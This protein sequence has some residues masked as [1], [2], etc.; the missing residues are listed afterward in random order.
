MKKILQRGRLIAIALMT[1]ACLWAAPAPPVQAARLL[2]TNNAATTIAA[3]IS[4]GATTVSV[5]AGTG[6]HFPVPGSGQYFRATFV[7]SGDSTIFE[8]VKVT[9][10]AG[11]TFTIVRAQEATSARSW[12]TGDSFTLLPTAADLSEFTQADDLQLAAGGYAADTG[13][14]NAY[15]VTLTPAVSTH[16]TGMPIRWKAAHTNTSVSTFNDGA[17]SAALRLADG[18]D[19]AAGNIVAGGLYVATWDGTKFQFSP[20]ENFNFLQVAG[21]VANAQVPLSAVQQYQANLS[22][23]W[24]Q[25]TGTKNADAVQGATPSITNTAN[26]LVQRDGAGQIES[27]SLS[28]VPTAPTAAAGTA[29]TQLATTA[30]V[31]Q[32]YAPLQ[33]GYQVLPSGV[34]LEWGSVHIGDVVSPTSGTVFFPLSFPSACFTVYTTSLDNNAGNVGNGITFNTN[35]FGLPSQSSFRWGAREAISSVQDAYVMWFAVGH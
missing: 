23:A 24:G 10:A 8:I 25:L 21:Q 28:G 12:S 16:V 22:I 9:A 35:V 32:A 30:F 15:A 7:K 4:S 31:T 34:I 17:G 5:A 20:L 14:T 33:S 3:P 13:S 27:P 19:L 11:D 29:T 2:F 18:T 6:V 1:A 26:S